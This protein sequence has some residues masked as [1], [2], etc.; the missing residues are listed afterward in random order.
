MIK[1]IIY[2]EDGSIDV[3]ELIAEL[4]ET[5]KVIV[6]RQG[7]TSPKVEQLQE[8]I[9]DT[10]DSICEHQK[11]QLENVRIQLE[12]AFGLKM[13]KKLKRLLDDLY[14]DTFCWDKGVG[15]WKLL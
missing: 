1:N 3:D 12:K 15:V 2:V 11:T 14:T 8:P 13:S 4:D 10:F 6:Y 7:S 5:T 9:N